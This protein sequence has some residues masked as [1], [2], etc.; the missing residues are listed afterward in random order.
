MVRVRRVRP[1]GNTRDALVHFAS[2]TPCPAI[3][4]LAASH[5]LRSAALIIELDRLAPGDLCRALHGVTAQ[6]DEQ[7]A[8]RG[9]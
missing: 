9:R 1:V 5:P 4:A 3:V 8:Q 7:P 6:I 2:S